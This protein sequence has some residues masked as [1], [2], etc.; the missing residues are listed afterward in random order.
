VTASGGSTTTSVGGA[1]GTPGG[2]VACLPPTVALI[3]DFTYTA[4]GSSSTSQAGF[5]DYTTTYSGG[6][7]IYPESASALASNVT[8]SNWHITGNVTDYAGFGFYNANGCTKIDASAY[9]GISFVI[10]GTVST[11]VAA[12]ANTV[13]LSVGTAADDITAAWLNA[14][15]AA[16]ATPVA[17]FGR[18]TPTSATNKYDGTCGGPQKTG[19]PVTTT[20]TTVTV[21][22]AE[23]T[24]GKPDASVTPS[25]LVSISWVL[26]NPTGVGTTSVVPY[27]V[28]IVVDD[29]Q[30]VP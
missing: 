9:K 7:F 28:D 30:F 26:P 3:T 14:N 16:G 25:E 8:Q 18:C 2:A 12:T 13:T 10:S 5:G 24:G 21:L 23:L 6:T 15:L 4:G 1:G 17:N 11:G 29:I 27:P 19:I 22:W 20:P